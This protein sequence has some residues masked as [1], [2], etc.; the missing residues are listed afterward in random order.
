M[1]SDLRLLKQGHFFVTD[2]GYIC[3][4]NQTRLH[5]ITFLTI[6]AVA[7][8]PVTALLCR[9]IHIAKVKEGITQ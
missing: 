3:K 7:S 6:W 8:I 1:P 2:S 5:M 9:I 4:S